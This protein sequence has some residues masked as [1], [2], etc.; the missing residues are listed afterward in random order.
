MTPTPTTFQFF[1][2][3]ECHKVTDTSI[4]VNTIF[5]GFKLAL[6]Y[7]CTSCNHEN[8]IDSAVLKASREAVD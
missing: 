2:C 4:P 6:H 5:T 1:R 3:V 8:A 7:R